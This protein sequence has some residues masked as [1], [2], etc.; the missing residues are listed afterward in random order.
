MKLPTYV[1]VRPGD[2]LPELHM[3]GPF[4]AVLVVE[5]DASP[6]WQDA[7]AESL[8][9]A[10]CLYV[11]AWGH[12]CSAWHD[13]VDLANVRAWNYAEIPDSHFVMTTWHSDEPLEEVF[14]F[15]ECCAS[16]PTLP[17]DELCIIHISMNERQSE[18]LEQFRSAQ[19]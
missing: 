11:L 9:K 4:K 19:A 8:V 1:H 12:N 15:A 7:I 3:D 5:A 2:V 6:E 17:L 13:A 18:I 16:H 10:E 14:W